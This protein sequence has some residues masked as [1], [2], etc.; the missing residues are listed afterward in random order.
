MTSTV[1]GKAL[2]NVTWEKKFEKK[3]KNTEVNNYTYIS[4]F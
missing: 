1:Y 4:H 3:G 2:A